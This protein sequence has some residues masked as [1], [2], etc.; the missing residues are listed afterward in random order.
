VL[1]TLFFAFH[2]TLSLY[3]DEAGNIAGPAALKYQLYHIIFGATTEK[4][5]TRGISIPRVM[6]LMFVFPNRARYLVEKSN[7][8]DLT[9]SSSALTMHRNYA[10]VNWTDNK[11]L[12]RTKSEFHL[13]TTSCNV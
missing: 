11:W 1:A 6:S 13:F 10:T 9:P 2:F 8:L 4:W 5:V 12:G 3:K 7:I